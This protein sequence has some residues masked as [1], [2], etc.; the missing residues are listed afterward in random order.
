MNVRWVNG[1]QSAN[2]TLRELAVLGQLRGALTI[3]D[4]RAALPIDR[5]TE[6]DV[7]RAVA[8]LE[9]KGIEVLVDPSLLIGPASTTREELV[10]R[11]AAAGPPKT[12]SPMPEQSQQVARSVPARPSAGGDLD[13]SASATVCVLLAAVLVC[14]L[15]AILFWKVW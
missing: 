4:I 1:S 13:R 8:Y 6:D 15:A 7:A 12:T 11:T 3:E 14:I 10:D 5:M 9:E 2:G